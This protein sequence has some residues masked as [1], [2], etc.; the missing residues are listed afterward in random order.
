MHSPLP[1]S[2]VPI[3]KFFASITSLT[4]TM[5]K[6]LL[7]PQFPLVSLG[8]KVLSSCCFPTSFGAYG[9]SCRFRSCPTI[10]TSTFT[11]PQIENKQANLVLNVYQGPVLKTYPSKLLF[12]ALQCFLSTIQ[13]FAIAIALVRDP[14]EWRLGWNVRLVAVAYCVNI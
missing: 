6:H 14:Y 3:S 8:L 10:K 7:L 9:S 4:T 2:R 12:T 1:F 11:L 13:S 5:T